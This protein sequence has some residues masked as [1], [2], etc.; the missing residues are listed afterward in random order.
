MKGRTII[1]ASLVIMLGCTESV[2]A[3]SFTVGKSYDSVDILLSTNLWNEYLVTAKADQKIEYSFEVQGNG[4][5]M[6]FLIQGHDASL[7]SAYYEYFSQDTPVKSFSDTFPVDSDDGTRFTIAVMTLETENVTYQAEIEV[8][9]RPITDFLFGLIIIVIIAVII[10]AIGA[11][12]RLRRRRGA[13]KVEMPQRISP[14]VAK[15]APQEIQPKRPPAARPATTRPSATRPPTT[16]PPA[17]KPPTT[18]KK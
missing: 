6:V 13:R 1:I 12:W 4:T 7:D 11:A 3:E 10:A 16:K 9:D 8:Y 17:T 14:P 15:Q 2:S 5:I 18:P